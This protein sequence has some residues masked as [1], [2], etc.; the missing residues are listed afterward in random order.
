MNYNAS[1]EFTIESLY[2]ESLWNSQYFYKKN[3]CKLP[4]SNSKVITT[5]YLDITRIS[6]SFLQESLQLFAAFQLFTLVTVILSLYNGKFCLKREE[7]A[8]NNII[9]QEQEISKQSPKMD[10]KQKQVPKHLAGTLSGEII[11][12]C[13]RSGAVTDREREVRVHPRGLITRKIT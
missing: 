11:C 1:E 12:N 8:G 9:K 7:K 5:T 13:T 10:S 4:A 2:T 3:D 6:V